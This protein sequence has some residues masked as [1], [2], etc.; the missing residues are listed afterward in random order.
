MVGHRR[1]A[2]EL[3]EQRA[4]GFVEDMRQHI[5]PAAMRHAEGDFAHAVLTSVLDD[6]FDERDQR[7]AAVQS[8]AFGTDELFV[9]KVFEHFALRQSFED[10]VFASSR[11]RRMHHAAFDLFQQPRS[12][13]GIEDVHDLCADAA[14]VDFFALHKQFVHRCPFVSQRIVEKDGALAVFG[15]KPVGLRIEVAQ[16]GFRREFQRIDLRCVVPKSAVGSD[17]RDGANRVYRRLADVCATGEAL[18]FVAGKNGG[19]GMEIVEPV[20][21]AVFCFPRR[22]LLFAFE[23]GNT[24]AQFDEEFRPAFIDRLRV[25]EVLP[26]ERGNPLDIGIRQGLGRGRHGEDF[27]RSLSVERGNSSERRRRSQGRQTARQAIGF[28]AIK[29]RCRALRA[30]CLLVSSILQSPSSVPALPAAP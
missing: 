2:L 4:M 22:P 9:Q 17:Q 20:E 3:G 11:E 10:G 19:I 29:R 8:E 25:M 7:F 12:F 15:S 13:S 5:Q 6:L 21:V 27:V 14:A 28:L 1:D 23:R 30:F 16:R 24:V 26:I 18:P